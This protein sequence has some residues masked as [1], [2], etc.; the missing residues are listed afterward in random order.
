MYDVSMRVLQRAEKVVCSGM[1]EC[2]HSGMQ[3]CRHLCVFNCWVHDTQ[4]YILDVQFP[5]SDSMRYCM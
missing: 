3:P 2:M 5:D 4:F 1:Q